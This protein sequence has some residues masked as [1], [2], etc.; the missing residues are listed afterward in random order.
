[1]MNYYEIDEVFRIATIDNMNEEEKISLIRQKYN[2]TTIIDATN[3]IDYY[4]DPLIRYRLSL[5]RQKIDL[6]VQC[7]LIPRI[8]R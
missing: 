3:D 4:L 5:I 2:I 1:M 6:W 8:T 7:G